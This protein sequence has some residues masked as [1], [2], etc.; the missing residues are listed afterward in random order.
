[1]RHDT[2]TFPQN[3]TFPNSCIVSSD[4][5]F[6]AVALHE[7][8]QIRWFLRKTQKLADIMTEDIEQGSIYPIV[9]T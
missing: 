7:I 4:T 1:M 6:S 8:T 5:S 2:V 9:T 3:E